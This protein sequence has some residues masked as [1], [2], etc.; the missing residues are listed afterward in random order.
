MELTRYIGLMKKE[1]NTQMYYYAQMRLRQLNVAMDTSRRGEDGR[2][3]ITT[4]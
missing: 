2:A 1:N 3:V 4:D